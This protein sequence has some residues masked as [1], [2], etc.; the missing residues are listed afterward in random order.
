MEFLNRPI[1]INISSLTIV[2]IIIV[3]VLLYFF[4]LIK[5][6]LAILFVSLILASALD[7]MVDWMQQKK[8]SRGISV[9][10]LYFLLLSLIITVIVLIIPPINQEVSKLANNFPT[11]LD[12]IIYGVH[13]IKEYSTKYGF[14]ESIKA[15]L[16]SFSANLQGT[17]GGVFST[18]S[19]IF[20]SIFSF[21]LVLVIT[22]YMLV[23]ENAM[24]KIIWSV[25]P[26][27]HQL[28]IMRLVNR[29]QVK[30]GLWLRGQL[31]L[32]VTIAVMV[33]IGL[34]ILGVEYALVLALIAGIAESVPYFGP[35]IGAIPAVFLAFTQRPM[36]AVFVAAMYYITQLVEN[37]IL[38]PKIM[39]KTVGLNPIVSIVAL[40]IG[41]KIAGVVGAI[42]SI[43]VATAVGVF[44]EDFF[45]GQKE[46]EK[47]GVT[48]KAID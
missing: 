9:L 26:G 7:P 35:T 30:I 48:V 3:A 40:M 10:M 2:K 37:N 28:Y 23:E 12:K 34:W 32:N 41:Y 16:S 19:G 31:I 20:G 46:K 5:D 25:V 38:A 15:S 44:L 8:I 22:F 39:E 27:E 33:Y 43:P 47:E 14:L 45:G 1:N 13:T 11:Y 29:M 4:Y 18:V 21:F 42:L 17:A 24:K 6:I 36:L